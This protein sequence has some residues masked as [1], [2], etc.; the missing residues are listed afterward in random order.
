MITVSERLQLRGTLDKVGGLE[1]LANITSAVPTT[2]NAKH[3]AKIIEEKAILRRLIKA[4]SDIINMGYEASEE[5]SYVLDK[6]EKS[7]LTYCK[8]VTIKAFFI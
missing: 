6:A 4:S 7:I 5:V 3:Y 1:Y 8:N 2:S